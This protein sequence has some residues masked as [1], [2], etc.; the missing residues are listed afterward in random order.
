[1]RFG[2]A[3]VDK[4]AFLM[5]EMDLPPEGPRGEEETPRSYTSPVDSRA[6]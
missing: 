6:I 5:K 4:L 3:H 2:R 1:M